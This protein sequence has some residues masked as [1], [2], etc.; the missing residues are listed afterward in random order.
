MISHYLTLRSG[1]VVEPVSLEE[2]KLYLKVVDAADDGLITSLISSARSIVEDYTNRALL[3]QVWRLTLDRFPSHRREG[4]DWRTIVLP[5]SPLATVFSVLYRPEDGTGQ[6]LLAVTEYAVQVTTL[7][8]GLTLNYGHA[9]PATEY[10]RPGAVEIVFKAGVGSAAA[11]PAPLLT[12]LKLILSHLYDH[13]G[14]EDV[15]VSRP[16]LLDRIPAARHLLIAQR[17]GG[18]VS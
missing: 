16:D 17:V 2:A 8:G 5:R 6:L 12:A 7:P 15:P 4:A 10:D 3:R 14:Q 13:R 18:F 1:P 9:W 11:V